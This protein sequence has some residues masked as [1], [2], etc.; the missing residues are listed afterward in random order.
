MGMNEDSNHSA[1]IITNPTSG[2]RAGPDLASDAVDHL[3]SEGWEAE[4][5][6]TSFRGEATEIAQERAPEFD[7]IF[8]CGGDGTLNEVVEGCVEHEVIVGVLPAGTAND[9]ARAAGIS[10]NPRTA[11]ARLTPGR[12]VEI[13]LLEIDGGKSWSAVAVGVGVDAR[14][15]QRAERLGRPLIGRASYLAAMTAELSEAIDTRLS[16]E[17]DGEAWEGDALLVQVANCPNHGGRFEIAPGARIDDGRLDVVL[18]KQATRAR[19]LEMIPLAMAGKH[20]DQ[21]EF[22]RWSAREV[23]IEQPRRGPVL[24]DGEV[25][26]RRSLSIGIAPGRLRMWLPDERE[27]TGSLFP[28]NRPS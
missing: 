16:L 17:I 3:R 20:V 1:L 18:M 28:G 6:V 15:V 4:K 19:A 2:R 24:I 22:E 27:A 12:P 10:L 7:V 25:V 21:P 9:L 5:A 26:E 14:T 23:T 11:A 8:S 13:D